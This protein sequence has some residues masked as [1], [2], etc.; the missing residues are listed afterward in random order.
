M[1]K[2]ITAAM[3]SVS[4]VLGAA[5]ALAQSAPQPAMESVDGSAQFEGGNIVGYALLAAFAVA[6]VW[7]LIEISD[8]EE[9][10]PVS[11]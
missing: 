7:A 9:D 11:P 1:L 5:P 3:A 8:D 4:L 6:S 2:R 10:T